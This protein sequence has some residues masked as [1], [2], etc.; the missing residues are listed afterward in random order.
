M[1]VVV[2]VCSPHIKYFRTSSINASTLCCYVVQ[3]MLSTI[4][5]DLLLFNPGSPSTASASIA[6][7][8]AA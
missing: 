2:D 5:K 1:V 6:E 7:D 3:F 8:C 4:A